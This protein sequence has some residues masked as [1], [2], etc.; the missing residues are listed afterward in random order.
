MTIISSEISPVYQALGPDVGRVVR[1]VLETVPE[2]EHSDEYK[3]FCV[4]G[5]LF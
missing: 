2:H 1:L 3:A 4:P 5:L